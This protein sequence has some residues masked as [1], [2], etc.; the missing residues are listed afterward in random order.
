MNDI[1][2]VS[3]C[4]DSGSLQNNGD[5]KISTIS[6]N[7]DITLVKEKTNANIVTGTVATGCKI[8]RAVY[9]KIDCLYTAAGAKNTCMDVVLT[10]GN[11]TRHQEHIAM[12]AKDQGAIIVT[13]T[14]AKVP[15]GGS[16]I[17]QLNL[18]P[19]VTRNADVTV[20]ISSNNAA[21]NISNTSHTFATGDTTGIDITITTID[22][23][24]DEGSDATIATCTITHTI[25]S[26]TDSIYSADIPDVAI[27]INVKNDDNADVNLWYDQSYPVK[28]LAFYVQESGSITYDIKLETEPTDNVTIT[29]TSTLDNNAV[30]KNAIRITTIENGVYC[31][32]HGEGSISSLQHWRCCGNCRL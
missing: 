1:I 9:S 5:F 30:S 27:T 15:E 26:T 21:C 2:T 29:I 23:N 11:Q 6:T 12:E 32:V 19:D 10:A 31:A 7:D 22:N 20:G 16:T 14:V 25:T 3:D 8:S 24:I 18:D 28:F 13:G 4:S 17:Y